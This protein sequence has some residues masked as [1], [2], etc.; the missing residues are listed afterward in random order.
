MFLE[1]GIAAMVGEKI[2]CVRKL[3]EMQKGRKEL[4]HPYNPPFW[5]ADTIYTP[6][7]SMIWLTWAS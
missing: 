6:A 1:G 4:H 3:K 2:G 7:L 5:V